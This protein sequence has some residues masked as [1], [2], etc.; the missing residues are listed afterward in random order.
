MSFEKDLTSLLQD[1]GELSNL[2]NILKP[3]SQA[4]RI[5]GD[6]VTSKV[7]LPTNYLNK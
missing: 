2:G 1:T 4:A 3:D 7:I 5:F 6:I